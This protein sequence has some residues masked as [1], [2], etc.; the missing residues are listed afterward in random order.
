MKNV[1]ISKKM[2]ISF[3]LV[4][5]LMLAVGGAGIVGI[6][7]MS[8]ASETL[9]NA[10]TPLNDLA[11]SMES[12]QLIRFY[13]VDA[14]RLGGGYEQEIR[15]TFTR[16]EASMERYLQSIQSPQ[17]RQ[18]WDAVMREYQST[19]RPRTED[20]FAGIQ[21]GASAAELRGFADAVNSS[22]DSVTTNLNTLFELREQVIGQTHYQNVATGR[23]LL[24]VIIGSILVAG[25][26]CLYLETYMAKSIGKPLAV[27]DV[28]FRRT[29]REGI[30]DLTAEERKILE[31]HKKRADEVGTMYGS[32]ADVVL[33]YMT[34][35]C[36]E[37]ERIA[38]GDLSL[39]IEV[40]SE[41]DTMSKTL[42][43]MVEDL[44]GMFADTNDMA[45]ELAGNAK[46][47]ADGAVSLS[48]SV[49]QQDVLITQL[50]ESF[51]EI[52]SHVRADEVSI[53]RAAALA[54]SITKNAE[55][56]SRQMD[57]MIEAVTDIQQA[58]QSIGRVIKVIEDIA[59]QTNILALNAA[60]EA[61]RAG[62]HGKGFA[63]VADEV[64]NLAAKSAEAAKETG[65][66][67]TNSMEKSELGAGIAAQTAQSLGRIVASIGENHSIIQ[68]IN[69]S[70][71]EQLV[72]LEKVNTDIDHVADITHSISAVAEE[73]A[74]SAEELSAQSTLLKGMMTRFKLKS[75]RT[76]AAPHI[77]QTGMA[78]G[79]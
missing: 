57:E 40:M 68:T 56:G 21:R 9:H 1:K 27:L 51:S 64:R 45:V 32:Y 16:F 42:K 47:I 20:I 12:F 19:V 33:W 7:S 36:N 59:F 14:I 37:L 38:G 26:V 73:S 24:W 28:W 44:A 5:L 11:A 48:Q 35:T 65:V 17:A 18:V 53:Q 10:S 15:Q 41:R 71:D 76:G 4:F 70:V 34:D 23:S 66:L 29:A 30:L 78:I 72:A 43:H 22:A 69:A 46:T 54:G 55:V 25:V 62:Q 39:D 77:K 50:S 63:V 60:V 79:R 8:R 31:E 58:G 74:S 75:N 61:A 49:S 67:I 13:G 6:V 52:M 3:G 2:L